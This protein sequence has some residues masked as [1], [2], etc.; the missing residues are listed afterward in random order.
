MRTF[1]HDELLHKD[2]LNTFDVHSTIQCD[3]EP[4]Q[5]FL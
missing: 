3:I 1:T 5:N 4:K 2:D